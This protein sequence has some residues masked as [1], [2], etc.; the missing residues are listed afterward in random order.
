MRNLIASMMLLVVAACSGLTARQESLLPAMRLAWQG[1]SVDVTRGIEE[2]LN[3]ARL[4]AATAAAQRSAAAALTTA[5][6]T[7]NPVAVARV[8]WSPLKDSAEFGL[9]KRIDRGEISTGVAASLRERLKN[10]GESLAV[11]LER[12]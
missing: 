8:A 6:D 12:R 11:F 5:L 9:V 2:S 10:F 1:A 4:D 3:A 7:G